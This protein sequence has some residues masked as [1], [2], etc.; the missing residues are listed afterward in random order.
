M[1]PYPHINPIAVNIGPL[2]I[3]WYSLAYLAG[4][5]IGWRYLLHII[6]L[7]TDRRHEPG[8]MNAAL[9]DDFLPWAVAGVILGGRLGYV[10]FYQPQLYLA[11]PLSALK[12]WE[13]GMSF[14]G[15]ALGMIVAM[16]LYAWRRRLQV[17]RLTDMVCAAVPIGLFFGRLANFINGELFGRATTVPWGMIFPY[18]GNVVRHPS[19]LYEAG[20]EGLVLFV[21]LYVLVHRDTI[22]NRPGIISG[23]FLIC[24]ACAR[25]SLEFFRQPD[26]QLGFVIGPF[27]MGQLLSVPM[28]LFGL[29]LIVRAYKKKIN[30]FLC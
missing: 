23:V 26:T 21:I 4:F 28:V 20:L 5:L 10:L 27:T 9:V 24:Y 6:H 25:M 22:R 19:Q 12:L 29:Y 14:H 13:G 17:L 7:D 3:R 16:I 8:R 11:H 2:P 18:G 15:G 30:N 1:I